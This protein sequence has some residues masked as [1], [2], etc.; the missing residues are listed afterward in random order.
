L[1]YGHISAQ[2]CAL[3]ARKVRKMHPKVFDL[4]HEAPTL[5]KLTFEDFVL[6][7]EFFS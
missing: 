3:E 1:H 5:P 4:L 6:A 2:R 7:T